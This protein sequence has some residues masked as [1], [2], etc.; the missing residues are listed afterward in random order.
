MHQRRALQTGDADIAPYANVASLRRSA[1]RRCHAL[2][3][4]DTG[5]AIAA[6][7]L[8]LNQQR[9]HTMADELDPRDPNDESRR[10]ED[11][12]SRS[13]EEAAN[14]ASEDEELEDID[15]ADE[16]EGESEDELE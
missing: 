7:F 3:T 11:S 2:V 15:E 4:S 6:R 14:R 1:F 8:T 10:S 12:R 13:D 16:D 9:R 5:T